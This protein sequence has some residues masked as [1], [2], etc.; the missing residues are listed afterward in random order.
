[1][2]QFLSA[3]KCLCQAALHQLLPLHRQLMWEFQFRMKSV[4]IVRCPQLKLLL[5]VAE[6]MPAS[7]AVRQ[8]HWEQCSPVSKYFWGRTPIYT[9][10]KGKGALISS[11]WDE[12]QCLH[13]CNGGPQAAEAAAPTCVGSAGG[14]GHR[15][16]RR[17][18]VDLGHEAGVLCVFLVVFEEQL[19]SLF[20]ECRV[21]EG[22]D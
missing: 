8:Q 18:G 4:R 19:P 9:F 7:W 3:L 12:A 2:D 1:M 11:K 15:P 10:E 21:R 20:I 14:E 22:L 17:L 6:A 13:A 16:L 5:A